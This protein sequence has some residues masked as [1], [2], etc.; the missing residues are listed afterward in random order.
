MK[1]S[2][3]V[4]EA[5]T[6]FSGIIKKCNAD[7]ILDVGSRDGDQSL[8]FRDLAPNA[9]VA[10]FEASP[11]NYQMMLSRNLDRHRIEVYPYAATNSNGVATFYV[12]DPASD[13]QALG[14]SS[15]LPGGYALKEKIDVETRRLDDFILEHYP[16]AQR[17]ALWMDV[18]SAEYEVL[19]GISKI[20]DRVIAIH[21][22]TSLKPVRENQKA[23][24]QLAELMKSWGFIFC[25]STIRKT[26]TGGDVVFLNA[27]TKSDMGMSYYSCFLRALI[28]H[29]FPLGQFAVYLRRKSPALYRFLR[30]IYIRF[31]T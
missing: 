14:A 21:T 16:D 26:H 28:L 31:A 30:G 6:L 27:K 15:L 18:E 10:A 4:I 23:F 24:P 1:E 25:G 9:H 19:E 11:A 12:A 7:C 3:P 5:R 17:I 29:Y 22:E 20:K 2:D 13:P 8:F